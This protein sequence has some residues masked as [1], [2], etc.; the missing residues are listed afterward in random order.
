MLGLARMIEQEGGRTVFFAMRAP[1]TCR[2]RPSGS[3]RRTWTSTSPPE[4]VSG[5]GRWGGWFTRARPAAASPAARG[6][7]R[8]CRPFTQ[9]LPSVIPFD[10]E[11]TEDCGRADRHDRPRL[12]AGLSRLHADH[13]R[14]RVHAVCRG[15]ALERPPIAMRRWR[16]RGQRRCCLR[17]VESTG[18]P[19]H[20]TRLTS[21]SPRARSFAT[22]LV[23]GGVA[24]DRIEVIPNFV[25]ASGTPATEP[26]TSVL[27]AGGLTTRR[28]STC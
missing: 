12:Q 11:A 8:R 13:A 23:E 28:E 18:A 17:I 7:P 10:P 15:I 21:S 5:S 3:F 9:Y 2:C 1:A 26:G 24:A 20:T 25:D 27:Y 19:E 4:P 22:R 16:R 6:Y 14:A